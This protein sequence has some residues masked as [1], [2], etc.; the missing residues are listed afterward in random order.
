MATDQ[1]PAEDQTAAAEAAAA[2]A[3]AAEAAAAE[4][5]A[6]EAAAAKGKAGK[7]PVRVLMDVGEHAANDVIMLSRKAADAAQAE[8]WADADPEAVKAATAA[9][10]Q[11]A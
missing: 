5:A 1:K 9:P 3:A 8:G 11:E 6:A 2:K 10:E 7:V 4:A